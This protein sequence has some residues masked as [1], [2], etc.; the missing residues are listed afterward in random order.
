MLP[1]SY[2]CSRDI[3]EPTEKKRNKNIKG[4]ELEISDY[5]V[6]NRL[7]RLIENDIV[8][9][10]E[11]DTYID[12]NDYAIAVE[13]D[14]SV[15]WEL[16]FRA[17]TN[18]TLLRGV[19]ALNT[20]LSP[21]TVQNHSGTSAHIHLNRRYCDSRNISPMDMQKVAEF[22]AY[23]AY[24][25]SG[26]TRERMNEWAHS[27]LA[28]SLDDNLLT[29]A[30]LVDRMNELSYNRYNIMNFNPSRT[31]EYRLFSNS[32][33][34]DYGQI[35]MFLEW[36]DM[37]MDLAE[38]MHERSYEKNLDEAVQFVDDYMLSKP[39]RK[40]W[41]E[42]FGMESIYLSKEDMVKIHIRQ[43]YDKITRK[44]DA[45]EV[46]AEEQSYDENALSFIRL[47]RTLDQQIGFAPDIHI[48]PRNMDF[49]SL[50]AELRNQADQ[51]LEQE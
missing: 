47:V 18:R 17:D 25:F 42:R 13:Y 44:I 36:T 40:Y 45:F 38:I 22:L 24:L 8:F 16:I 3:T 51:T 23:P 41:Y 6:E 2:H 32:Y 33:G 34:F 29:R 48:N 43:E 14:G 7:E 15:E 27:I 1:F 50:I 31:Y 37:L 46:R 11:S 10:E 4:L 39:R 28:C 30:K 9:D 19:K 5:S 49:A 21:D 26:R 20:E 12:D 35:R